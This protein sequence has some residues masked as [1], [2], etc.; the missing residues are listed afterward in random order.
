M[1]GPKLE[2]AVVMRREPV[3]GPASRWQAERW[4]LSEVLLEDAGFG[5]LP[6]LLLHSES[7]E[8]WLHPGLVVELFADEAAGYYLNVTTAA[9]SWFVK[10]RMEPQA[11]L[12]AQPVALPLAVTLS[13]DEA[14]R[15][16]DAQE[17]V[18]QLPAPQPVVEWLREFVQQ[19]YQSEP[20]QRQRPE[21]FKRL[22][23][24]FGNPASVS[25]DKPRGSGRG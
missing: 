11:A 1:T 25:T 7:E 12:A 9:P 6:R 14:A 23:D 20:R 10:W 3:Q 16:L 21:S 8:R 5:P 13:Y 2:V 24:R 19:H 4:V 17:T 18:E 22:S 15:W